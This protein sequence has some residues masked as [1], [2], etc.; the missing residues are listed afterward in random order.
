MTT[1]Q[2]APRSPAQ[3]KTG[4]FLKYAAF[5][6]AVGMIVHGSDHLLR[7]LTGDDRQASWPGAVQIVMAALTV[8]VSALAIAVALSDCRHAAVASMIIGFGSAAVFLAIHVLPS[9]ASFT[10]S[11]VSAEAGARVSDYS[12]ITA[13][14]GISAAFV[15]GLAGADSFLVARSRRSRC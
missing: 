12:W 7:G 4:R 6:Y 3:T 11:F 8:G 14:F 15:L 2:T 10:D 5:C 1:N 9:W 13:S